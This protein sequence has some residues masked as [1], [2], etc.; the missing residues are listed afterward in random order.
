MGKS[1]RSTGCLNLYLRTVS[2]AFLL[3]TLAAD[4][5]ALCT[6]NWYSSVNK[7]ELNFMGIWNICR[8]KADRIGH[9]HFLPPTR[10]DISKGS[11]IS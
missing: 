3:M 2:Y 9:C 6:S 11:Y 8:G 10:D 7:G 5:I 4:M 1:A